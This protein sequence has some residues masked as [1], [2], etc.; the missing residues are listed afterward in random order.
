VNPGVGLAGEATCVMNVF[1]TQAV[2]MAHARL[3]GSATVL[4][5][6]ADSSAIKVA[7]YCIN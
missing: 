2:S 4:K 7:Y 1:D 6:G 3:R 5:D